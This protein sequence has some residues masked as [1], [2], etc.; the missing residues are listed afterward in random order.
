MVWN[1]SAV[2]PTTKIQFILLFLTQMKIL[3]PYFSSVLMLFLI[4]SGRKNRCLFFKLNYLIKPQSSTEIQIPGFCW[5]KNTGKSPFKQTWESPN[6]YSP[7]RSPANKNELLF[8]AFS[9][10]CLLPNIFQVI[11]SLKLSSFDSNMVINL[12]QKLPKNDSFI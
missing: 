12:V 2:V 11:L 6:D 9:P 1:I 7:S 4:D 8:K 10:W 3:M 5:F